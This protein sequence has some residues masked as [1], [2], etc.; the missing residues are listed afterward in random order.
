VVERMGLTPEMRA[1]SLDQRGAAWI[2]SDGRR[3]AEMLVTAF[4]GNGLISK[5]EILRGDLVNVL[6]RAAKGQTDY[7]FDTRITELSQNGD[8]VEAT[9]TDGTKLSVDLVV[10]ADGPHSTVR[11]LVFGPEEQFVRPVPGSAE[12]Y[13]RLPAEVRQRHC[14]HRPGDEV[15]AA[16]AVSFLRRA[17]AVH[18]R[19][20]HRAAG[21]LIVR[22]RGSAVL[23]RA[24]HSGFRPPRR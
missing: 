5:L 6:Y 21:L 13:R 24:L 2:K 11:R 19:R 18:H 1:R 4:D 20:R 8:A 3:R 9:L 7:R 15:D 14:H 22:R 17:K 23:N 10:G 16:L 12:R